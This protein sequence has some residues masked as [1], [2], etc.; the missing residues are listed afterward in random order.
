MGSMLENLKKI[1]PG[2]IVASA[3]I[4]AG[5]TV[6]AVR[7]GAWGGYNLLWLV[8]LA[9]VTK[10]FLTLYLLGRYSAVS[11][12]AVVDK[13]VELPGPRGWL[14]WMILV[15]EGIVAPLVFVVIAVPCGRIMSQVLASLGLTVSYKWLALAFVSLAIGVGMVQQYETLEKSQLIVCLILLSGTVT[16][17]VLVGPDFKEIIR[18]FFRFGYF[19][20]YP[21]WVPS[22]VSSRSP[23]LEMASVFGYAGSIPMNYVVYSNWV[24]IKGWTVGSNSHSKLGLRRALGPLR[25]DVGFNA[26]LVLVVTGAF[27]VAGAAILSPLQRIPSGFDL[28]TE[29]AEIFAQISRAM[30]P[31]Y[32]LTILT[33]L[34]GTLN[35][36]PE[37]YARGVHSFLRQ[38]IPQ[39]RDLE[40]RKVMM[41]F[42]AA[43][44]VLTW[45]LIWTG[46]TPIIMI[47]L[48]ALFST[49]IGVGLVCGAAV[50][51]DRQLPADRRSSRLIW[52]ATLLSALVINLMALLSVREVVGKYL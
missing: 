47:D 16:A 33:A 2:A 37:I 35:A 11:G 51:L 45:M 40:Y 49:N 7:A 23:L 17:T 24:L 28:L 20:P 1:G 48:V 18:G 10:S 39:A 6:L 30:I 26:G 9:A 15:L 27:M 36:L 19:P 52:W 8:L 44:F 38:L 22:E 50:W 14:L 32:Y 13:L 34:W 41:V 21:N 4:G 31:L 5:E 3:T 12:Q 25:W 42:G 46:T 29:Q 43:M